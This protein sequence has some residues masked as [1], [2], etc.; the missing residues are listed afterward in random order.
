M[1]FGTLSHLHRV[2]SFK[3]AGIIA[4]NPSGSQTVMQ[5]GPGL[6][7]GPYNCTDRTHSINQPGSEIMKRLV[8]AI[9][10]GIPAYTVYKHQTDEGF[11]R[12]TRLYSVAG[13]VVL[14]YRW[15]ELK[16]KMMPPK[17]QE[18]SDAEWAALESGL[19]PPTQSGPRR[20]PAR[21]ADR[22]RQRRQPLLLL[23][24][25]LPRLPCAPH[26]PPPAP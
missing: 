11:R 21:G 6:P 2:P 7:E 12:A 8:A 9:G 4:D 20:G 16:Q 23:P 14:A 1:S 3:T 17:S 13:P 15:T 25:V 24:D 5:P 22:S 10:V 18:A 26:P 19:R